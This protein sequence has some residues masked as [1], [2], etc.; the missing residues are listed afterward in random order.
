MHGI[1]TWISTSTVLNSIFMYQMYQESSI[2]TV[3]LFI[4][5]Y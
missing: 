4:V 3:D 5:L 1:V 2:V